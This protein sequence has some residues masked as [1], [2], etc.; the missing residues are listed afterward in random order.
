MLPPT[1]KTAQTPRNT[2]YPKVLISLGDHIRSRRLDLDLE[3]KEVAKL[4]NTI[5]ETVWNWENNRNE[6]E[7]KYYPSIMNF[8]EYCPYVIPKTWG[9]KLKL[10]RTHRGLT[11]RQLAKLT[12]IDPGSLQRWEKSD[13]PPWKRLVNQVEKFFYS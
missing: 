6:P 2:A 11:F 9:E 7:I 1:T 10:F 13:K 5:K 4:L 8:L 12:E 3:Q